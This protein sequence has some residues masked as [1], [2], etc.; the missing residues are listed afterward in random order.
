MAREINNY[1]DRQEMQATIEKLEKQLE[2]LKDSKTDLNHKIDLRRKQF[3]VLLKSLSS[4][5]VLLENDQYNDFSQ[6]DNDA[7][8]I[9]NNVTATDLNINN[10]ESMKMDLSD[11]ENEVKHN[12]R[13]NHATDYVNEALSPSRVDADEISTTHRQTTKMDLDE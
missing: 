7:N 6:V 9:V 12:H 5:K 13:H 11:I 4:L 10:N 1:P 2:Q 3:T 8:D